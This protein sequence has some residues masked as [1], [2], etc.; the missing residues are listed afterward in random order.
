[1]CFL[2]KRREFTLLGGAADCVAARAPRVKEFGAPAGMGYFIALLL[3]KTA[4][5]AHARE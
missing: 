2:Y 4:C 5:A 1:M 3:N